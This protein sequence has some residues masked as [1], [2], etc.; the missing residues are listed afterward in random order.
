M[1]S[2]RS[3]GSLFHN[4]GAAAENDRSPYVLVLVRGMAKRFASDDLRVRGT[5]YGLSRSHNY[6]LWSN[7]LYGLECN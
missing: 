3:S 4:V 7:F 1:S 6:V 5:E 2:L